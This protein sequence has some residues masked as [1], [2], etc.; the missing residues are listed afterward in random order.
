MYLTL[1]RC[2]VIK[3]C[4]AEGMSKRGGTGM[5]RYSI[6]EQTGQ[7]WMRKSAELTSKMCWSSPTG[8]TTVRSP[9]MGQAWSNKA[10]LQPTKEAI[11][12]VCLADFILVNLY[13]SLNSAYLFAVGLIYTKI[14]INGRFCLVLVEKVIYQYQI[15]YWYA[16]KKEVSVKKCLVI[17]I[18]CCNILLQNALSK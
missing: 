3:C 15:N 17:T 14:V 11:L 12:K 16:G 5:S 18:H 8:T 7:Q 6:N 1:I 4:Y 10:L 9:E 13:S 2:F